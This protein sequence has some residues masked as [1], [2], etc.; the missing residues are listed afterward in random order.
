MDP[1]FRAEYL[2]PN[3]DSFFKW[4]Q[5]LGC[6]RMYRSDV[7]DQF[8]AMLVSGYERLLFLLPRGTFKSTGIWAALLRDIVLDRNIRI[9]HSSETLGQAKGYTSLMRNQMETNGMLIDAVGPFKPKRGEM[10]W[11]D[12]EMWVLGRTD[13]SK[14]EA[15]VTA[16]GIEQVKA[17][18]HYDKMVI[19]D[20][21][22]PENTRT[23]NGLVTTIESF[24]H[25]FAIAE[26]NVDPATGIVLGTTNMLVSCTRYDDADVL[27]YILRMNEE[28]VRQKEAGE[29]VIPWKVLEVP[30]ED[31]KGKFF[32]PHLP[33]EVLR[34]KEIEMGPR[35]YNAQ[36]LLDPVPGDQAHFRREQF[37]LLPAQQLPARE[38]LWTYLLTDTGTGGKDQ[39]D[40]TCLAVCGRDA[41]GRDYVL[42][43]AYGP[44]QPSKVV[45]TLFDLYIKWTCRCCLMEKVASSDCYATMIDERAIARQVRI[46]L[47]PVMGRSVESKETRIDSLEVPMSA[48]I[49]YFSSNLSRDLIHLESDGKC[50]GEL[51]EQFLRFP[52]GRR[53]D[54]PDA[55]SDLYKMDARGN[56]Y[57]PRPKPMHFAR[58]NAI[59]TV[60]GRMVNVQARP[61]S[62][63]MDFWGKLSSQV[64][65]GGVFNGTR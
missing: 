34:Q 61:T 47:V 60:N 19:D 21:C 52:H 62:P 16:R 8:Y 64:G 32:F 54:I 51:V 17:G 27:G 33:K 43:M 65:R 59:S 22:S 3:P 58:Q 53:D 36:M 44:M 35:V 6:T 55:L 46:N 49:I 38:Y 56:P 9:M 45:D 5:L 4:L 10:S 2:S 39:D 25:I 26:S 28:L 41:T 50:Y 23:K 57:C 37:K 7:Y 1:S 24:K 40:G 42:D 31:R 48:G 18:P 12:S 15:T 11:G 29:P 63:G 20:P 13:F 14:K 30:A